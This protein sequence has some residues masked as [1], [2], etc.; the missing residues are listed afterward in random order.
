MCERQIHEVIDF[1]HNKVLD[2]LEVVTREEKNKSLQIM[3]KELNDSVT[4]TFEFGKGYLA[5]LTSTGSKKVGVDLVDSSA[6][7]GRSYEM[8]KLHRLLVRATEPVMKSYVADMKATELRIENAAKANGTYKPLTN[9]TSASN[10]NTLVSSTSPSPSP[11]IQE[12]YEISTD[13]DNSSSMSGVV[14]II[15]IKDP[16]GYQWV[17]HKK[18]NRLEALHKDIVEAFEAESVTLDFPPPIKTL[19]PTPAEY[20]ERADAIA[21]YLLAV[22][23]AKCRLTTAMKKVIC[24]F[25]ECKDLIVTRDTAIQHVENIPNYFTEL[26][27]K[28]N[29]QLLYKANGEK[30]STS[31]STSTS[32][33]VETGG[34]SKVE[35][36]KDKEK[37]EE[38][39]SMIMDVVRTAGASMLIPRIMSIDR[40]KEKDKNR[41]K[42]SF[43]N[44]WGIEWVHK[45]LDTY[46][47]LQRLSTMLSWTLEINHFFVSMFGNTLAFSKLPLRQILMTMKDIISKFI[48]L[49]SDLFLYACRLNAEQKYQWH[50]NLHMTENQLNL[51]RHHGEKALLSISRIDTEHLD[52]EAQMLRLQDVAARFQPLMQRI[53]TNLPLIQ[54]E[55]QLPTHTMIHEDKRSDMSL[56]TGSGTDGGRGGGVDNNNNN[57]SNNNN[58]SHLNVDP[59]NP[60]F[61]SVQ[62]QSEKDRDR[63]RFIDELQPDPRVEELPPH[64]PHPEEKGVNMVQPTSDNPK[65]KSE[66]GG[67][68]KAMDNAHQSPSSGQPGESNE[69]SGVCILC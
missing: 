4:N 6:F 60:S 8:G 1:V 18:F 26:K 41:N 19:F 42:N 7:N 11:I 30:V 33:G 58:N 54:N 10:N 68:S 62:R 48:A 50:K 47:L 34:S 64:P 25:L 45:I 57:S 23:N 3:F 40:E 36:E 2:A 29:E 14:Y 51:T 17:I 38:K 43:K 22:V 27:L 66:T 21:S 20:E 12:D 65:S 13:Y 39:S 5:Y 67:D 37:K 32:R 69:A 24:E 9:D 31:T 63:D 44:T 61:S 28:F 52:Y 55:L 35:K 56:I 15:E 49:A 16:M 59:K 46:A 53:G